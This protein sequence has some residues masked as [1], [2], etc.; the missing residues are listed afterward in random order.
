MFIKDIQLNRSQFFYIFLLF[1]SIFVPI[2]CYHKELIETTTFWLYRDLHNVYLNKS[3][4]ML[5]YGVSIVIGG[6]LSDK[7]RRQSIL[8]YWAS[9]GTLILIAFALYWS[10]STIFLFSALIGASFGCGLPSIFA[11]FSENTKIQFRGRVAGVLQLSIYIVV[12]LILLIS[13]GYDISIESAILITVIIRAV[14]FLI[15]PANSFEKEPKKSMSYLS[16]LKNRKIL[17]YLIPWTIFNICNGLLF[18]IDQKLPN[19]PEYQ[20]IYTIGSVIFFIATCIFGIVS[21]I[22]ADRSGRKLSMIIGFISLGIAYA[23]VGVSLSPVNILML[24]IFQGIAWGIIIVCFQ[25]V[26]FGDLAGNMASEKLYALGL[27]IPPLIEM[28]V[29]LFGASFNMP[30]SPTLI[31]STIS[32]VMFISVLPLIY[33]PETLPD[34]LIRDRRFKEYLKKVLEIV[35]ESN[36]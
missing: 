28:I 26:V 31:A 11:Y 10:T 1:I 17:V 35:E 15:F 36:E 27:A 9:S 5:F 7:I 20:P 18:F 24:Y 29:L 32:I 16:I 6:F 12:L 4:F 25:Y 30:I 13:R 2:Y 8:V 33:A 34:D 14:G 23:F 21:G 22:I 19:T 3:I